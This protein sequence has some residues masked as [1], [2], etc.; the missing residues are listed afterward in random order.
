MCG[1]QE[2]NNNNNNHYC[3]ILPEVKIIHKGYT[4]EI[5]S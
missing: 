5:V 3:E 2:T 1:K 4:G